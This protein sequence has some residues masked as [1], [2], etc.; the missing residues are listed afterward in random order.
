[1]PYKRRQ[2]VDEAEMLKTRW[3]GHHTICQTLREIYSMTD[4]SE[5]KLKT[6]LA[7]A[8]AKAMQDRLKKYKKRMEI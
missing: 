5:I 6:R 7:M 4:D 3:N 8:M 2:P 1:M